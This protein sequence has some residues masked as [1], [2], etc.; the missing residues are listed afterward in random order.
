MSKRKASKRRFCEWALNSY[1]SWYNYIVCETYYFYNSDSGYNEE[2]SLAQSD[3]KTIAEKNFDELW[4]KYESTGEIDSQNRG[5]EWGNLTY[6]DVY[7]AVSSS[8][9]FE[10][11]E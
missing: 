4:L 2:I 5:V 8:S 6:S 9:F 7:K 3:G 10:I 1:A 11:V